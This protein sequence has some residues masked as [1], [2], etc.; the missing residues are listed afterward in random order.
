MP[1]IETGRMAL[2]LVDQKKNQ[3]NIATGKFG[4]RM[5]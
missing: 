3:A 5:I 4:A 2:Y 1:S